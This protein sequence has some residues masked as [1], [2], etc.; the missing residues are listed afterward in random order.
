MPHPSIDLES[1]KAEIISLFQNDNSHASIAT[2]LQNKY[3]LK[4]AE[5]TIRSCLRE[6][7]ICKQNHTTISDTVLHAQIKI[8]FFQIWKDIYELQ[9]STRGS[10]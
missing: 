6:W 3:N 7:V 10:I 8:L 2:I 9:S 4:I 5:R 1:Y